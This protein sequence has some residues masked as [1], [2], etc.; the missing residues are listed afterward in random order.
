MSAAAI[1]ALLAEGGGLARPTE[2]DRDAAEA[3]EDASPRL[4]IVGGE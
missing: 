4:R 1:E 2:P 3:A